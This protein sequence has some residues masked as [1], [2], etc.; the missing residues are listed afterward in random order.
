MK[1]K[2][3]ANAEITA[4]VLMGFI[5]LITGGWSVLILTVVALRAY[6]NR[7][8]GRT[9]LLAL[10]L[11]FAIIFPFFEQSVQLFWANAVIVSMIFTLQA[12]GLNIVAGYAGLLDLGYVA[13]FAIGGYTIAMLN[14]PQFNLQ[15]SFWLIIWIA[16]AAAALFGLILGAPV[17]PL[18]GD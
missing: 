5:A 13:F 9:G 11:F 12:L 16:A 14:S 8:R 10:V 1:Q 2:L 18:R 15:V 3:L 6:P 4:M 17:L 7:Q